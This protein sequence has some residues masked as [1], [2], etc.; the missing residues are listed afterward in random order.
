M[1]HINSNI[2]KRPFKHLSPIQWGKIEVRLKQNVSIST[3]AREV[4]INQSI[5]IEK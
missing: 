4:K 5:F 2:Q 1:S 3:I